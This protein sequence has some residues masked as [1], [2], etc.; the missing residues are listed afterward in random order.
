MNRRVDRM[1]RRGAILSMEL[2]LVL[3]IL[4]LLI[5]AVAEFSMLT[6][7]QTKVSDAARTGARVLSMS[8]GNS[9]EIQQLVMEILG[10]NLANGCQVDVQPGQFAGDTGLVR[11]TV[12]MRNATPDLLWM[13][14]FS[15]RGR[16]IRI[17][18]PMVMEHRLVSEDLNRL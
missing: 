2:V 4:M 17:E 9:T 13:T 5:F 12:P 15:V 3:P 16:S 10:P 6:S 1:D 7:A 11:V 18:A 14:G 8:G